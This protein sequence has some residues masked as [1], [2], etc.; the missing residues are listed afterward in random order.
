METSIKQKIKIASL[1]R[2]QLCLLQDHRFQE[3]QRLIYVVCTNLERL[4]AGR[5]CL[6]YSVCHNWYG[7]AAR[8][9]TQME[10][11]LRDLPYAA[12]QAT[13]MITDTKVSM[14]P[15][16]QI[17]EE[18][19]QLQNEFGSF[20]FDLKEQT[21]SVFTDPIELEGVYLGEFEIRLDI[22]KLAQLRDCTVF[23][24]I[25]QDPHPAAAND[26]ITHPHVS[27]EYICA[28]DGSAALMQALATGRICDAFLLV[29]SILETYN[30]SSP[31]IQLD[32]WEGISC[33]D[34]GYVT[35]EE[36]SYY[37]EACEQVFCGECFSYCRS[38]DTSLCRCCLSECPACEEPTCE[39]CLSKCSYCDETM[40][41]S[42]L[43]EGL[44]SSCK[45]EMEAD[46][47]EEKIDTEQ[48][49]A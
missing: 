19:I 5:K 21:I 4:Q 30:P 16:R 8:L 7:A 42:C 15:L 37:C 20:E 25:A 41:V 34:C 31:Y 33:Y 12:E 44:C 40:C 49:V 36:S 46:D 24:I 9:T 48:H 43:V 22:G 14:P 18:L 32:Q 27:E 28:G 29:K 6:E 3:V 23:Q 1:I 39:S 38:C 13:R 11:K 47:E 35:D 10:N 45:E 26:S 17:T 2:E